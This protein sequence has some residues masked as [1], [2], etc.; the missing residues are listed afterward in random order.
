MEIEKNLRKEWAPA[1]LEKTGRKVRGCFYLTTSRD[2]VDYYVFTG[3][4]G[5]L[6]DILEV[7][8]YESSL[9]M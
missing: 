7:D 1:I 9:I 2:G 4:G 3:N 8:Q 5:I 6:L